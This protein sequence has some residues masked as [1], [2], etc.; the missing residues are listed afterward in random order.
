MLKRIAQYYENRRRE[1][2][3]LEAARMLQASEYKNYDLDQIVYMIGS[4]YVQR[5]N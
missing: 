4:D 2:S 5:S 1:R 3:L